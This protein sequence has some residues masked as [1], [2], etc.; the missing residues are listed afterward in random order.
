M[1]AAVGEQESTAWLMAEGCKGIF[2]ERKLAPLR[3]KY[4][5]PCASGAGAGPQ[6]QWPQKSGPPPDS[7]PSGHV[8]LRG[9][10][11]QVL[12]V[13]GS[14]SQTEKTA[15]ERPTAG[16]QSGRGAHPG[17]AAAYRPAGTQGTRTHLPVSTRKARNEIFLNLQIHSDVNN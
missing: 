13:E 16:A 15:R 11:C 4:S 3:S 8:P 10:Q 17:R 5:K 12:Q 2:L 6:G 1:S 9:L 14:S 7:H